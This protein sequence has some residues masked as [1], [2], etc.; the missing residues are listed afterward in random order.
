MESVVEDGS[1]TARGPDGDPAPGRFQIFV[2]GSYRC[3]GASEAAVGDSQIFVAG[4]YR[5]LGVPEAA[6]GDSQ[7]I[8]DGS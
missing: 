8:V 5:C 3:L 1:G 7:I 2:A 6:V 4:S